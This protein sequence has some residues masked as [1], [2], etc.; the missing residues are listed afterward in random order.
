MLP[1]I[2]S[3]SNPTVK[4]LRALGE[5]KQRKQARQFV[6][7]GV[8]V[9]EDALAAGF[10]PQA[11]LYDP[12]ALKKTARGKTLL[13][14]L[15]RV[16]QRSDR[17]FF[18]ATERAISAATDTV[19][20]QGIVASFAFPDWPAPARQETPTLAL[21]CDDIQDPGNL[22]TILRT[23]EGAGVAAV[24]LTPRCVDLYSPKV[25]RAAMGAHF[26]LTTYHE[27]A[28]SRIATDL[29]ALD[30]STSRIYASDS[31]AQNS[32]AQVD[33]R[34]ASALIVS[35]EAHG[36]G[37]EARELAEAGGGIISIP[38]KGGTESLNAAMATAVI[39]FEAARQRRVIGD[40]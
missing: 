37:H 40:E 36:L 28:W 22:G 10:V 35:N 7:E 2:D 4:L 31:V 34:A 6:A 30:V 9:V 25:V 14:E 23:A 15:M 3:P 19:H 13:G 8:R 17:R 26:R 24:W 32:Y 21:I 38:M 5:L 20:P 1:L 27:R 16:A 12:D 33:W 39:L 11:C 29:K 18:A